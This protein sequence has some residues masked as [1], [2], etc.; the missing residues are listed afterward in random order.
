MPPPAADG[1]DL[2]AEAVAASQY[3]PYMKRVVQT[4]AKP[5]E[6][7]PKSKKS[8]SWYVYGKDDLP[9]DEGES[10]FQERQRH[11]EEA[12][13]HG[14]YDLDALMDEENAKLMPIRYEAYLKGHTKAVSA[15]ALDP[16]GGRLVSAGADFFLRF[17]DFSSMDKSLQSFRSME[18]TENNLI[19]T[20]EWTKGGD[21]LL[22][23]ANTPQAQ[24]LDREGRKLFETPRG[25][26]Y[27]TDMTHTTGHIHPIT[28]AV[29]DPSHASSRFVTCSQD[30]TVRF[31]D[32]ENLKKHR[33]IIKLKNDR[34]LN[35]CKPLC[36]N[37][38]EAHGGGNTLAVALDD[39]AIQI[40]PS[41]GPYLKPSI[42]INDAHANGTDT[43][44]IAFAPGSDKIL[45]TRGGDDTMKIWDLR[46]T[47][48]SLASFPL[49][50]NRFPQTSLAFKP[51]GSIIATGTSNSR[52]GDPGSIFFFD[53]KTFQLLKVVDVSSESIISL[54]WHKSTNQLLAGTGNGTISVFFDPAISSKGVM[55]SINKAMRRLAIQKTTEID[56]I[57]PLGAQE[58]NER[59]KRAQARRDPVASHKPQYPV[60]G[61]GSEGLLGSN[62][63][64]DFMKRHLVGEHDI[65]ED[66][67]E[68]LLRKAREGDAQSQLDYQALERINQAEQERAVALEKAQK[69]RERK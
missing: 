15:M 21:R 59:Q 6:T 7:A 3:E 10:A 27:T 61:R 58:L 64:A 68:A 37:F 48:S 51:D 24:I 31:W 1:G 44:H 60:T 33:E 36:L 13:P 19:H 66:P 26:Q 5:A 39:G 57:T 8:D 4:V 63:K 29:W 9:K 12:M 17:W 52:N 35:T 23:A 67:R 69:S 18:P 14:D 38:D 53:L 50:S 41:N 54:R 22:L 65:H 20:L 28:R 47:K 11:V 62:L 32:V 2:P 42:R 55:T 30:V 46:N 34:G 40:F 25:Y 43:S 56:I 45:A 16:S 49:L